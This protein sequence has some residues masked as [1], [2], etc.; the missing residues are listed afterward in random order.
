MNTRT[1]V[2]VTITIVDQETRY[3]DDVTI[4]AIREAAKSTAEEFVKNG[5]RREKTYRDVQR[6][7]GIHVEVAGVAAGDVSIT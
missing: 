5:L 7:N 3:S 2:Q 6:N 4:K 1:T